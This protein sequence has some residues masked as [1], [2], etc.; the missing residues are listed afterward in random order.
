[1]LVFCG[2]S[3]STASTDSK[4]SAEDAR[5]RFCTPFGCSGSRASVA[6]HAAGFGV[7]TL[8]VFALARRR[9]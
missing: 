1:M 5:G 8:A 9:R 6:A 3:P 4:P 2:V 7:A